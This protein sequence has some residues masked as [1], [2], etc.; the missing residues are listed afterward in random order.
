MKVLLVYPEIPAT[1]WSFKEA[2]SFVSKKS[3][4]PP[5]GL[6]TIAAM[7]PKEWTLKLI[8][9]N[10]NKL[11]DKD[12]L[13]ADYVF[14]SGMSIQVKSFKEVIKKC[15]TL[16]VKVVAGGPLATIQ[17]DEFLGVEHFVLNEAEIT[18]PLFLEDLKNG[19]PKYLYSTDKF[20][21]LTNT[22]VPRWDLLDMNKYAS[23]SM[24]YTRGC[25]YDCDFCS[26]TMLNGRR[27]RTKS[28]EQFITELDRLYSIGWRN[29]ISIVDDNFIGN[30]KKLKDELL[31]A[32][33]KWSKEKK[34]PYKFIT[35]V[36]INL[37]DDEELA[38]MMVEAGV[39]SI[40]VGIE[41]PAVEGLEECGKSQNQRRDL[42]ESVKKLQRKGF[43]VSAGFIVGFDSDGE[44]IF[45]RQINF[46]KRSGIVA[47]MVGLLNAP[48]GTKLFNR[49]KKEDRLLKYFSGDNMDGATNFIPRMKYS[50]LIA[51]Y[52]NILHTIYSH[53]IFYA[54]IMDFLKEYKLPEWNTGKIKLFEVKAF[55]KL[56]WRIGIVDNGRRYFWHTLI[57]SLFKYPKKFPIAMTFAVY[58]FHFRRVAGVR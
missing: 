29:D 57:V 2:L 25:P 46:I 19:T 30:K 39:Y 1:F 18:L 41:T 9:M 3:A 31:P 4:E 50:K 53:K 13:W 38:S 10:V 7:L 42:V 12:I 43:I 24:Q 15:N 36:S 37:A 56:L 23:M 27:P 8:D 58:G 28:V 11:Y 47:A 49:M 20:P 16:G 33:I 48:S 26:I 35:E 34:Y 5:L 17:H 45:E 44:D 52:E 6:I 54:R 32:L 51:G 22:P 14:L 55:F 40:F 21:E